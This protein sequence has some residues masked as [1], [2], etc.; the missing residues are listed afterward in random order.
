M[1]KAAQLSPFFLTFHSREKQFFACSDEHDKSTFH[2][3]TASN[4]VHRVWDGSVQERAR[5]SAV[6]PISTAS[7]VLC[8]PL[9]SRKPVP[10]HTSTAATVS[11]H[12]LP[13]HASYLARII[14]RSSSGIARHC[15]SATSSHNSPSRL[16]ALKSRAYTFSR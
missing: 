3:S 4:R 15:Q 13:T 9:T 6:G 8:T 14:R 10:F 1:E 11:R 12:S 16:T 2:I 5:I 7:T